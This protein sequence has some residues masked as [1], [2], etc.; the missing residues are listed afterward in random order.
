M[1]I[2]VKTKFIGRRMSKANLNINNF[3]KKSIRFLKFV[4]LFQI[5]SSFALPASD[6]PDFTSLAKES[7]MAVVNI[8]TTK[9]IEN[10]KPNSPRWKNN[11]HG[12]EQYE[13]PFGDFFKKFFD[14]EGRAPR[15]PN[16]AQS[17]GSGFIV[18]PD[19][20]VITNHHVI[21]Q[22]DE[23]IV[24]LQDRKEYVAKIVGSD[25]RSDIAL[26]KIESNETFP[27]LKF[28]KPDS[29]QVG[30]WVLAI[31]SPFGFDYSVTAGIV[32]AMGRNLPRDNYVPFIQTDVAINPG[33]SG[34]PLFNLKGEVVGV[35]S[36]IYSRTGGFMGL[37]FAIP[38][39]VVFD[40]YEQLKDKGSVTRGWLGILI[41]EVSQ[42]IAES[43]GMEQPTGALISKTIVDGPGAKGGLK[44]GDIIIKFN[45]ETIERSSDL[46]P[47]VGTTEVGD[48]VPVEIVRKGKSKTVRI[49]IGELP[50][51]ELQAKI[52]PQQS[53]FGYVKSIGIRIKELTKEQ[54]KRSGITTGAVLI[55]SVDTGAGLNAGL[56]KGDIILQV[57]NYEVE[58]VEQVVS[59][60]NEVNGARKIPI[61][62]KRQNGQLFIVLDIEN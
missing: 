13:G 20:Y 61:L 36:Q 53:D 28:A 51:N 34:G 1:R 35:N 58:S 57:D 43:F 22:A 11:P 9:K 48:K 18:S 33:N 62:I 38:I 46:P 60:F 52:N 40:V 30:E 16:P 5:T 15:Q 24:R 54:Q 27:T 12:F 55:N 47:L 2:F 59:F 8:S 21:A 42:E 45:G 37:S 41:Q 19:G 10:I 7:S 6:L 29:L 31:G 4:I 32:S 56:R 39:N 26:L 17:L 25:S 49:V 23:V 14:E 50:E 44:V 3:F